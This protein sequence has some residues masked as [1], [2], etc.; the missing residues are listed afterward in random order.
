MHW[1]ARVI[2][3]CT[4]IQYTSSQIGKTLESKWTRH[5][6]DSY[7]GVGSVSNWHQSRG[8]AIW[9]AVKSP[10][11]LR[12]TQTKIDQ[13]LDG[14]IQAW[15]DVPPTCI[16]VC[17]YNMKSQKRQHSGCWWPGVFCRQDICNMSTGRG[18]SGVQHNDEISVTD[19]T[20]RLN[21]Q[22]VYIAWKYVMIHIYLKLNV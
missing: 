3:M 14:T 1:N 11:T 16:K 8:F 12:I 15:F 18:V 7:F 20:I 4:K 2:V 5:R 13:L 9:A 19:R 6:S 22:K 10:G 17:T 21:C